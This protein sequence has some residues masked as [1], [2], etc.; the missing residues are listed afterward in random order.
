MSQNSAEISSSAQISVGEHILFKIFN[1]FFHESFQSNFNN[2]FDN[3]ILNN[4][5]ITNIE[6]I[7]K[8]GLRKDEK[9]QIQKRTQKFIKLVLK[10]QE[11]PNFWV[12]LNIS[13]LQFLN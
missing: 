3:H 12:F 8:I 1:E 5:Q 2:F 4:Q 6:K 7:I 11:S 9:I 13:L 10:V